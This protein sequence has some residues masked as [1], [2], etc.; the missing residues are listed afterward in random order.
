[1]VLPYCS[2]HRPTDTDHTWSVIEKR[3]IKLNRREKFKNNTQIVDNVGLFVF[4]GKTRNAETSHTVKH[5]HQHQ[6]ENLFDAT[7][8]GITLPFV[9]IV[10]WISNG[11]HLRCL[12][13]LKQQYSSA[14]VRYCC[15]CWWWRRSFAVDGFWMCCN[16]SKIECP[17]T[18]E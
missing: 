16:G 13:P 14:S 1:M 8:S 10:R 7:N 15:R 3:L 11:A 4:D 17:Q 2:T 5:H 6:K 12:Y 18:E 9:G